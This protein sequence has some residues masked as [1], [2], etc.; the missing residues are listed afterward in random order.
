[1]KFGQ[2]RS[3]RKI[4]GK[5]SR[6]RK[7]A[8]KE[9]VKRGKVRLTQSTLILVQPIAAGRTTYSFLTLESNTPILPSEVRLNQNDEFISYELGYYVLGDIIDAGGVAVGTHHHSYAPMELD[10][11]FAQ[12]T[13]AWRGTLQMIINKISYMENWDMKKHNYI[14]RTQFANFTG[15]ATMRNATQPSVEFE[16]NGTLPMQPMITLS[17]AKKND[18]VITLDAG[19]T[20]ASAGAWTVADGDVLT[21]S[22][23]QL[24]LYFRGMLAQNASKFQ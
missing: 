6:M 10:G 24:A 17:G 22:A 20:P 9:G 13:G 18:I 16:D 14:A 11:S 3:F 7:R 23:T 1:M 12:L 4:R 8:R 15:G 2:R 5:Y 21:I 19:I